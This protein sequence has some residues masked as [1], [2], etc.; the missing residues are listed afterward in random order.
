M[1]LYDQTYE[2]IRKYDSSAIIFYEPVTWGVL[3]KGYFG[4]GFSRPPA[5]DPK[6]TALSWHYYCWLLNFV[7]NPLK[8]GTY[9]EF[10][11][12]ACD[13]IQ[14]EI[15]FQ[16]VKLD[17]AIVGGG[18]SFLTEF[19]VCA[20]P[21]DSTNA[22]SKL[23]TDECESVLDTT[24]KYFQSWTYWDSY[25]YYKDSKQTIEEL[26]GIFSRVYPIATNGIPS[27]LYFNTTSKEFVFSYK[28]NVSTMHQIARATYVPTVIFVPS[29]VYP[30]GFSI[31]V[32]SHLK[33]LYN[34][35]ES[36]VYVLLIKAESKFSKEHSNI[37][38]IESI[39][40]ISAIKN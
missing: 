33:W 16:A 20:F 13:K 40:K 17:E 27:K 14:L 10:D 2:T 12:I 39:V 9:P 38:S 3:Y 8:N 23:N 31:D 25:F 26:V 34:A 22:H 32:S 28:L 1:K 6:T 11:K 29:H 21:T 19:G 15:S 18:P 37:Q 7:D 30:N 5:N 24:D 4:T 35:D 36:K